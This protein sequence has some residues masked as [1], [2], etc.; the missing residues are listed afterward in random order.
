MPAV[1]IENSDPATTAA[2]SLPSYVPRLLRSWPDGMT[3]RDFD[4]TLV[5]ADLSGFTRLS[6][7][8]AALGREG[9]EELTVLLNGC[10]TRMIAEIERFGGDVLKFGGDALLIL[11]RGARN[12]ERA[13]YTTI[14]MRDL[15]A[16]PLTTSAGTRVRLKIS[17]GMHAGSF[18]L[19]ILDG[20]H[21]ELMVTGP[22]VTET[23]ECEGTA[24]AGQILLSAR[25]AANVDR[26]WLGREL[27]GRRLLKRI[28]VLDEPFDLA[29]DDATEYDVSPFVPSAQRELIAVGAP[30]EH[31]RVTIG[32]LKFSH[33]DELLESAGTDELGRRLQILAAA[34]ARAEHDFGVHWLASDVYPDGGKAIL[35]AGAPLTLGDDEE[36][37]LRA[38]RQILDEVD[39]LDLRVGVN[40]G[41]VFVGDLGSPSRRAFTV[42]GDAVNLAARLMQKAESGELVASDATL[43]RS[44]TQF[45][46]DELE[47]FFVKGKTVPIRASTVGAVQAKREQIGRLELI[48][49]DEELAVLLNGARSARTGHGQIV[50]IVGEPGA[51][52]SRLLEELRRRETELGRLNVQCGQ[53][54][55]TSPYFAV[56]AMLRT[57]AGIPVDTPPSEAAPTLTSFV[58]STAPEL[59]PWLP[60]LAIPFD[61]EIAPTPQVLRIAPEFRRA[62]SHIAVADV[63]QASITIPT[64]MLIEDLHW[65]DD[66]SRDLLAELLSR[67]NN[68]PWLAVLTRRP[69]PAPLEPADVSRIELQPLDADAALALVVA[70]AG[71]DSGLHKDDWDRLVERAG[72]NP[73]FAI[74]LADAARTMGTA[75]V[76]A[77]SVESLVTSKIDTLPARDRLLLREG[78]VL[79]AVID[80]DLLANALED[81]SVRDPS[82]WRGLDD[83]LIEGDGDL[84]FRHAIHQHVAYEGLPYRR[85]REMHARAARAL[86]DRWAED[87]DA[88]VGLLST[89]YSRARD[90]EA[91]WEFSVRAGNEARAKYANVEAAE[92]Y[93][94][95]LDAARAL[96][97]V[98]DPGEVSKVA[99]SLGDACN[100]T[101]RYDE[102]RHAYSTARRHLDPGSRHRA[103]LMRKEGRV[104]ERAGLYTL[105]LRLYSRGLKSLTDDTVDATRAGLFAAYGGARYRQGRVREAVTWADRA[106]TEADRADDTASLALA[107]R[108]LELS[109]HDLGDPRFFEF[110]GRSLP[111]LEQLDDQVGLADE[112][113][114][115]GAFTLAEGHFN[116]AIDLFE[117]SRKA[118]ERAGDVIGEASALINIG[119]VML[120]QGRAD[121]ARPLVEQAARIM[122]SARFPIGLIVALSDLGRVEAATGDVEAGL[123]LIND[124]IET[125]MSV[126]AAFVARELEVRKL[127]TLVAAGRDDEAVELA[128]LLTPLGA[129]ELEERFVIMLW[130]LRGWLHLRRNELDRAEVCIAECIRHAGEQESLEL[131]LA[132]RAR[133]EL[134][135]RLGESDAEQD[136]RR[137][138]LLCTAHGVVWTPPLLIEH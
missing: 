17:Q 129:G 96:A 121:E 118:R 8:L 91:A 57:I 24:N 18:S 108:L 44:P 26:S 113:S 12:T 106:I 67:V 55:R 38:A 28:V 20:N 33:T 62:R 9:A 40:A 78:S 63:I 82:R 65:V 115:L 25:A 43:D 3:H 110:R 47:A 69:G 98:V 15:I 102:A 85:R 134:R 104:L 50:E 41:P 79:G 34:I 4:G 107:L 100:L 124:A 36:R 136:D 56:R 132:L 21:R 77:D 61:A 10:F 52:K 109:L 6:E 32:F 48:G 14:A 74:E 92:F 88:V 133:A 30:A 27:D 120:D 130:R 46:R 37:V 81:A 87:L 51:G 11:Y 125:A 49:R 83:F 111:I 99:E 39:E 90:H 89:H 123:R 97:D 126:H 64:I 54:A 103:E 122:H 131:G 58:D 16:A 72:G 29:D 86:R 71:V 84:R 119:E 105:A 73:L 70:A 127:E 75:D 22:G 114:N 42:M 116:D 59:S 66:A 101:T 60:L 35:T 68:A 19:F 53:Y 2:G 31:R 93:T 137:A 94:R 45:A 5:S 95:A 117:R 112:L 13:C 138:D 1:D 7:R 23:V 128:T 135:R 80:V 76:V